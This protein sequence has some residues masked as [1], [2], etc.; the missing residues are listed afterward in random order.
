MRI[1][2][3]TV[4]EPYVR[5]F[6]ANPDKYLSEHDIS[7][8]ILSPSA[9][10]GLDIAIQNYF[11]D[12]FVFAYGTLSVNSIR[13]LSQRIR[14]NVPTHLWVNESPKVSKKLSKGY[15]DMIE[16]IIKYSEEKTYNLA[17]KQELIERLSKSF[18]RNQ[19]R[20]ETLTETLAVAA[21]ARARGRT[22]F[23]IEPLRADGDRGHRRGKARRT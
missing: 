23:G 21:D 13:Q 5:E 19:E 7:G 6:L 20:I 12:C 15:E 17:N 22:N 1:D 16:E 10:S 11:S 18:D 14:D 8:L 9:E 3:T 4:G 2:S